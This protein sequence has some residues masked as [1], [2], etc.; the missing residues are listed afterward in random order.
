MSYFEWSPEL[1]TGIPE[2]DDQHRKIVDYI[3]QLAAAREGQDLR[4]VATVLD[5]LVDYTASHFA[6]EE[7]LMECSGYASF[8]THKSGHDLFVQNVLTNRAQL[9][10]GTD[11]TKQ[12]LSTLKSWL[13]YHIKYDD[14]NY[15]ADVKRHLAEKSQRESGWFSRLAQRFFK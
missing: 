12:L 9:E 8:Q 15:V 11:I 10:S 5:R 13:M 7:D 6:L 3:N 14:A 4:A 1:D 2:I